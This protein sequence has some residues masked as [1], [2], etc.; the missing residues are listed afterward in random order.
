LAIRSKRTQNLIKGLNFSTGPEELVNRSL[1]DNNF[2]GP[3]LKVSQNYQIMRKFL[4]ISHIH[5]F[6]NI[7][8]LLFKNTLLFLI[9]A[10]IF[11]KVWIGYIVLRTVFFFSIFLLIQFEIPEMTERIKKFVFSKSWN[12]KLRGVYPVICSYIS[13]LVST[14]LET[15]A[16]YPVQNAMR[17]CH[18]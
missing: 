7:P 5:T 14:P 2:W 15:Q 18:T 12:Y 17:Y 6:V 1:L 3:S 10:G 13:L 16:V 8:A 4:R 11:T 9:R